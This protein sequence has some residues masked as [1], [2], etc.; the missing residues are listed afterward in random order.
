MF[1]DTVEIEITQSDIS[2][3]VKYNCKTCAA[4]LGIH[5]KLNLSSS[6]TISTFCTVTQIYG[7]GSSDPFIWYKHSEELADFIVA[8][9]DGQIVS[10]GIYTMTKIGDNESEDS[11]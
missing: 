10:P 8:F 11:N 2:N 9:D 3:G 4:A 1:P 6:F 5:R 7:E